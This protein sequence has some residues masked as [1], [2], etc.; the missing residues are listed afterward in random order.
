LNF[1]QGKNGIF[2]SALLKS[3]PTFVYEFLKLNIDLCDLFL[4]KN[5]RT[6]EKSQYKLF[7]Q[8]MYT[9]DIVVEDFRIPFFRIIYH[10]S[11]VE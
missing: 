6:L 7:I 9:D 10:H 8:T 2:Q 11:F 4:P 1:S 3:L 5:D